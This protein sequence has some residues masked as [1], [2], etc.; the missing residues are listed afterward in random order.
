L[1]ASGTK[2]KHEQRQGAVK[3]AALERKSAGIRLPDL[4][5]PVGVAPDRFLDKDR[6]IVDRGNLAEV[7]GPGQRE[8]QTAGTAA[9]IENL[10]AIFDSRE[11][12][13][14]TRKSLAP[15]A[16]ELLVTS[17]IVDVEL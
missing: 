16:H 2:V 14:W 17:G 9:D 13:K 10:F 11:L 1:P 6:R 3:H 12:D 7:G 5:S 15:A 8:S 4:Y